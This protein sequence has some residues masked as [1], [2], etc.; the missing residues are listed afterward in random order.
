VQ[1]ARSRIGRAWRHARAP[2]Y[3]ARYVVLSI[4][5]GVAAAL[6]TAAVAISA[7]DVPTQDAA[8]ALGLFSGLVPV[9]LILSSVYWAVVGMMFPE[10]SAATP[11]YAIKH[12]PFSWLLNVLAVS[13]GY[14]AA[15]W[16]SQVWV[17]VNWIVVGGFV[18]LN[19]VALLLAL[20][21]VALSGVIID[22]G[23]LAE[24][25]A[26]EA[27][28]SDDDAWIA[29]A[30]GDLSRF[31]RDLVQQQRTDATA[32]A[33]NEL[34]RVWRRHGSK[35][36]ERALIASSALSAAFGKW[37]GDRRILAAIDACSEAGLSRPHL[38]TVRR[39]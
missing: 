28:A 7:I 26:E 18:A 21:L 29:M 1:Q 25:L 13:V 24:R 11:V 17:P 14:G 35:L 22:P 12:S 20:Q 27:I 2:Y 30:V 5:G 23:R 33:I 36:D 6:L 38:Q 4:V 39:Q 15:V 8:G 16:I 34:A 32:N 9:V 3:L 19:L 31:I 10:Y 37:P